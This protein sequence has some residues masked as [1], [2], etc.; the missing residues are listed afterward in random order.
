MPPM[1]LPKRTSQGT[2]KALPTA[3]CPSIRTVDSRELASNGL[4]RLMMKYI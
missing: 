1:M 3:L 2:R 4:G